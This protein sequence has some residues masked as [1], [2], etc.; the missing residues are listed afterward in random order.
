M[1]RRGSSAVGALRTCICGGG[2]L[3]L[4]LQNR[5]F[6]IVG[7]ELR[8]GY[9]LTEAGPVSLFNRVDRP[10]VRGTLGV[11][12]PGVDVE[13]FEPITF[14]AIGR[15]KIPATHSPSVAEGEIC[16]RGENVF[17][18]YVSS[19]ELGLSV[20][21]GWLHSGDLG[22]RNTDGSITFVGLVKPMFTRN[23]FNIYPR[24]IERVVREMPGVEQALVR[25]VPF[26]TNY[27][28]PDIALEVDGRVGDEDVKRWCAERL[29]VYKQPTTIQIR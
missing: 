18:G 14:D 13:L 15:A 27:G 1:E 10:S 2:P 28:E 25:A 3:A 16:V 5:W 26:A 12:V 24:E 19:G 7:V 8:E 6:D 4:T 23:G 21:D 11:P 20:H 17:R 9:G 22:R 29:S